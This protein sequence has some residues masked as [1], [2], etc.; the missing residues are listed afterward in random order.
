[1]TAWRIARDSI[2]ALIYLAVGPFTAIGTIPLL[3]LQLDQ[4]LALPRFTTALTGHAGFLLMD[5]AA[6]LPLWCSWLMYH[7]GR[8]SPL[9]SRPAT[10]LVCSGPYAVVRHP[11]MLSLLIV[12]AGELLVSG[13][14]IL[15]IWMA[16]AM[17]AGMLFTHSYEEPVLLA[18]YGDNYRDYCARVPPWLPNL[19]I[20][21]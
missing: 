8:G 6:L 3:L 21:A 5:L 1:V 13:S 18:R 10:R 14:I 19:A 20:H 4:Q 17:R 12:G 7:H 16:V 9:P 2:D 15:L 11:M